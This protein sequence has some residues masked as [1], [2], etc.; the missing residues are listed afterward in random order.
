MKDLI[1]A[2][3]GCVP[4]ARMLRDAL[5]NLGYPRLLVTRDETKTRIKLRYGNSSNITSIYKDVINPREFI[6]LS[7]NKESFSLFCHEVGIRAPVFTKLHTEWPSEFPALIRSTLTGK[8]CE[9][10]S[11]VSS[12]SELKELNQNYFWTPYCKVNKEYRVHVIDGNIIRVFEKQFEGE[13]VDGTIIRNNDNS[14]FSLVLDFDSK[15]AKGK[16]T[17]LTSVVN[18]LY[19]KLYNKYNMPLMFSIDIGWDSTNTNYIIFEINTASGLVENTA[20]EYAKHLG[21]I[22]FPSG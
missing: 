22:L 4:S 20:M 14:H 6:S 5:E 3:S 18:E 7:A 12:M 21:R 11:T 8:G 9:G 17:K 1:L 10:I 13:T 16:F 2:N 19:K 15:V